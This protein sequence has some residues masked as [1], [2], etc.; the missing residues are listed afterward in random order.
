MTT[1]E[2]ELLRTPGGT[3]LHIAPCPHLVGSPDIVPATEADR[4][5]LEICFGCQKEIRGEGR[6]YHGS[7]AEALE[8]LGMLHQLRPQVSALLGGVE[9]DEVWVPFSRSYVALGRAGVAVA[10]AG[11]TYVDIRGAKRTEFEGY[12]EGA[13]GGEPRGGQRF[14][15]TCPVHF[16][17]KALNGKCDDCG[18]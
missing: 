16:V 18:E 10:W 2:H 4:A 3:R 5:S 1:V 15:E 13:G 14:G 9:H 17:A 11:R 7:I 8:D 12:R 6:T